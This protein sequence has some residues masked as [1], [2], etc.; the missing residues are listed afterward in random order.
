MPVVLGVILW[1]FPMPPPPGENVHQALPFSV[2]LPAT[3]APPCRVL[4]AARGVLSFGP[5]KSEAFQ[6][7][8]MLLFRG[9]SP[10]LMRCMVRGDQTRTMLPFLRRVTLLDTVHGTRRTT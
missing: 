6:T 9:G 10:C 4:C 7:R 3:D 8:T 1:V 2:G 5:H